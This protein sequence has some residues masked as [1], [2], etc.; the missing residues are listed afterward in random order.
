MVRYAREASVLDDDARETMDVLAMKKN[1]RI[2]INPDQCKGCE[3]CIVACSRNVL[4]MGGTLNSM[5]YVYAQYSGSGCIGCRHCYY[6]CP[7]PG[8]ITVIEI[9]PHE[10]NQ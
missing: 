9:V 2:E 6:T 3:R 7:E 1:Y 5:G 8:A 10:A 4:A